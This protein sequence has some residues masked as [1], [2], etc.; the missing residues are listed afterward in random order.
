M[1]GNSKFKIFS[2]F[3]LEF[4]E[5]KNQWRIS[6]KYKAIAK[7]RGT[8]VGKADIIPINSPNVPKNLY[9]PLKKNKYK[10]KLNMNG[11]KKKD[12]IKKPVLVSTSISGP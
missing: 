12:A 4:S 1:F 6:G 2:L 8:P 5:T 3:S 11:F 7:K 9:G 10:P